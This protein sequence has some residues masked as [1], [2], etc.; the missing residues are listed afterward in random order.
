M[1]FA[2]ILTL[3]SLGRIISDEANHYVL[4]SATPQSVNQSLLVLAT[5]TPAHSQ[6]FYAGV[7]ANPD[8]FFLQHMTCNMSSMSLI[9]LFQ[10]ETGWWNM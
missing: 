3:V 9:N 6:H 7:G 4:D 2:T 10:K 1:V 5:T 8:I